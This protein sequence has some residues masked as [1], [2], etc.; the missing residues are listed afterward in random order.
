[1]RETYID[2]GDE[3][4]II[5]ATLRSKTDVLRNHLITEKSCQIVPEL[6][7]WLVDD[8]G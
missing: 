1:M 7:L 4:R 2:S 8:V 3:C 5:D 6:E